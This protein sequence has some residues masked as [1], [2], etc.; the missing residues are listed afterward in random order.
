MLW[1]HKM[2]ARGRG[3]NYVRD[4]D[5]RALRRQVETLQDEIRRGFA[6]IRDLGSGEDESI[7]NASQVGSQGS[8]G[9]ATIAHD[10]LVIALSNIGKRPKMYVPTFNGSLNLE[11]LIDWLN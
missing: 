10:P 9:A 2:F 7:E 11:E 5:F 1:V 4:D 6:R 3:E 8:V